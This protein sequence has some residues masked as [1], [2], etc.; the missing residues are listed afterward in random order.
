MMSVS[1]ISGCKR[2][3]MVAARSN[4][5]RRDAVSWWKCMLFWRRLVCLMLK[6][7]LLC[8]SCFCSFY[9]CSLCCCVLGG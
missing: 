1:V 2:R 9:C 8:L 6:D 5:R 3:S 4:A 7:C